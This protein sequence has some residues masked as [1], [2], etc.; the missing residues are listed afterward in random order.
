MITMVELA[1]QL[2]ISYATMSR[3][4]GHYSV[5]RW[6]TKAC[7][8]QRKKLVLIIDEESIPAIRNLIKMHHHIEAR[9]R[10]EELA[11]KALAK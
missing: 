8:N 10:F 9:Y 4:F 2:G 7:I 11:K 6:I 3:W 5:T 1:K